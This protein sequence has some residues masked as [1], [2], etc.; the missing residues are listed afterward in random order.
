[1]LPL[2]IWPME[3]F[4]V[5]GP[6]D[7]IKFFQFVQLLQEH[8]EE[9][10]NT[11]TVT[12]I[13]QAAHRHLSAEAFRLGMV[14]DGV[15]DS[16]SLLPKNRIG[17]GLLDELFNKIDAV[18]PVAP[19]SLASVEAVWVRDGKWRAEL[20]LPAKVARAMGESRRWRLRC[21][22][23]EDDNHDAEHDE[24]VE[25]DHGS[26]AGVSDDGDWGVDVG[27]D[28]EMEELRREVRELNDEEAE[29]MDVDQEEDDDLFV[30]S[31][32][33]T[34]RMN[35]TVYDDDEEEEG[36]DDGVPQRRY[37]RV[38]AVKARLGQMWDET[39]DGIGETERNYQSSM[40]PT[41]KRSHF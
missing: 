1:M 15:L 32:A 8:L 6:E 20:H 28:E 5:E 33:G 27:R 38:P 10:V 35:R 7:G 21:T 9:Q 36:M 14:A 12:A 25:S 23:G 19:E 34:K 40:A 22:F 26:D 41:T 11:A 31:Y 3:I 30:R 39:D 13:K 4:H 2:S 24:D 17:R 16:N 29:E 37:K 18:N